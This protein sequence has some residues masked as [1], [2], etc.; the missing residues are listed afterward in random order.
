MERTSILLQLLGGHKPADRFV[1]HC[2]S[3]VDRGLLWLSSSALTAS[4][5]ADS[6]MVDI[7]VACAHAARRGHGVHDA[8]SPAV[9]RVLAVI[10]VY[11]LA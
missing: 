8:G 6:A 5:S 2:D 7:V 9:Q 1:R 10:E 3:P 4:L 11:Y